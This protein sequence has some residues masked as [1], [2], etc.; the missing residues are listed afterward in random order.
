MSVSDR[1]KQRIGK[2]A[3]ATLAL[4][5]L[6]SR[7]PRERT[8]RAGLLLADNGERLSV[9]VKDV[10]ETGARVEFVSR[11]ELPAT[12]VLIE[13]TLKLHRRAAVVWQA[14]CAAGLRF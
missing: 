14:D 3:S 8:F 10:N 6:I 12:V 5:R 9:V 13:P 1:L 11:I 2:I 4:P 7:Q